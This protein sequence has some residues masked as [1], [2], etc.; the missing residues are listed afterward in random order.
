MLRSLVGSEMCIRDRPAHHRVHALLPESTRANPTV[1]TGRTG[2]IPASV[3]RCDPSPRWRRLPQHLPRQSPYVG[4]CQ[5]CLLYTSDAADD[6][7]CVDLGGRR[8]TKKKKTTTT[9]PR[10]HTKHNTPPY[11]STQLTPRTRCPFH[12]SSYHSTP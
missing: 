2:P 10:S 1:E 12:T 8:N 11:S 9:P 4:P 3:Y 5:A 7:L 6:L